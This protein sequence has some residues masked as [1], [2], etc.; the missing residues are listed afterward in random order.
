MDWGS[1]LA[2]YRKWTGGLVQTHGGVNVE[3][4]RH[5]APLFVAGALTTLIAPPLEVA[6][7]AYKGDL[8]FP[9]HLRYGYTSPFNAL[10]RIASESPSSLYKHATPTMAASFIQTT[11]SIGIYDAT[12]ELFSPIVYNAGCPNWTVKGL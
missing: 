8:T 9:E 3:F 5:W 2:L 7:R 1:R 10:V 6:Y 12:W 4:W 11:M